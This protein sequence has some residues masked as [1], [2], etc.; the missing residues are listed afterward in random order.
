MSVMDEIPVKKKIPLHLLIAAGLVVLVLLGVILWLAFRNTAPNKTQAKT[1]VK[2]I[3]QPTKTNTKLA[4]A[5]AATAPNCLGVVKGNTLVVL[6]RSSG[7]VPA[8]EQVTSIQS[9]AIINTTSQPVNVS[10]GSIS[11]TVAANKNYQL[12][13]QFGSY[14]SAGVHDMTFSTGGSAQI[15]VK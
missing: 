6:Y 8:C 14:L 13:K 12:N 4:P 15:W 3:Q 7:P 10:L 2:S 11:F 5:S 9:L 1:T